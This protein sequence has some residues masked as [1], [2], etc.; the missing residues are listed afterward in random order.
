MKIFGPYFAKG[1]AVYSANIVQNTTD[2]ADTTD[3]LV[4]LCACASEEC[5]QELADMLNEKRDQWGNMHAVISLDTP[6]TNGL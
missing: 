2:D 1:N 3:A 5:A 6:A 4:P